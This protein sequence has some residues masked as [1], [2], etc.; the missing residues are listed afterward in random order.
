MYYFH[1][2]L[3]EKVPFLD[4][5]SR[6]RCGKVQQFKKFKVQKLINSDKEQNRF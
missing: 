3:I 4:E 6:G 2:K 1:L 5:L